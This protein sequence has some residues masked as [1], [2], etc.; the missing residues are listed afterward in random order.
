[1][2]YKLIAPLAEALRESVNTLLRN[3]NRD[4]NGSFF[5]A[6]ELP[7]NA[8]DLLNVIVYDSAGM[9]VGGVLA[10]TQFA[11]LKISIMAVAERLRRRGIGREL[12][13]IAEQEAVRRGCRYAYLDTM[14]YQAPDFY[15]KLGYQVIGEMPDWDSHG[16]TAYLFTKQLT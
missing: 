13:R 3:Y 8:P 15:R 9:V 14:D 4:R 6:R 5:T 16:H 1:M 11:W 12:M 2:Q 10:E 7:E